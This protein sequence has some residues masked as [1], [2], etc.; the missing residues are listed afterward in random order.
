MKDVFSLIQ[1][2]VPE[3]NEA[4]LLR[5]NILTLLDKVETRIGRK[6]VAQRVG[7]T[8]RTLRTVIDHMREQ[9]LVD[10]NQQGI[11]LTK[12]GHDARLVLQQVLMNSRTE[13]FLEME[14][15]LVKLLGIDHC[16]VVPGDGDLDLYV[17]KQLGKAVQE[18]LMRF[19]PRQE[20]V[21]A[22]TGGSTLARIG[23]EFSAE[24][25]QDHDITFVPTRGGFGGAYD[26]QSNTIGGIMA[27]QTNSKYVPFFVPE[28]ISQESSQVLL[29]DPT[30][31]RAVELSKRADSLIL[32][33]GSAEIIAERRDLTDD[34]KIEIHDRSSVG[35]AFGVFFDRDGREVFKYPRMGMQLEDI[36]AV[37]L[38]ITV[39]AG[40]KKAEA[41]K[42]FYK[43]APKHGWL[44]C[45][46]GIANQI[47]NG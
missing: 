36:E 34:Q 9:G 4:L 17:Y 42:A 6:V 29:K 37:P 33:V 15:K 3:V 20:C 16:R 2:L 22:V 41:V 35:E 24:L 40:K 1:S 27:Q 25:S 45:D 10:V 47:I 18:I 46:E 19:L 21:V 8:E 44:V 14:M 13:Q 38:L 23:K 32:S 28:N 7:M 30:I 31:H 43:L 26:I 12:F 39:V 5:F 11:T